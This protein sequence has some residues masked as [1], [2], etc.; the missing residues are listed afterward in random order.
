MALRQPN[1]V[2]S[3][4]FKDD[5]Q[6]TLYAPMSEEQLGEASGSVERTMTVVG[7]VSKTAMLLV[8]LGAA[9]AFPYLGPV[10]VTAAM[11]SLYLPSALATVGIAF[12]VAFKPHLARQLCIV[13]DDD[14]LVDQLVSRQAVSHNSFTTVMSSSSGA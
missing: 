6:K 14:P 11:M 2:L 13:S 10:G 12:A 1:P 7:T 4:S 3:K 5:I 9:A 8:I